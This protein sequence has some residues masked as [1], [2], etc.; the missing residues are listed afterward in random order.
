MSTI[1]LAERLKTSPDERD[2][3]VAVMEKH[4]EHARQ[5]LVAAT[6]IISKGR[7]GMWQWDEAGDATTCDMIGRLE[8]V[9]HEITA[10][11]VADVKSEGR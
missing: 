9:K 11:Y 7:D 8:I 5:G 10:R 3:I 6:L 4:L 2:R 1:K